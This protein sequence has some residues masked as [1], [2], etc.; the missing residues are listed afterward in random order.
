MKQE[1]IISDQV[2]SV[3]YKQHEAGKQIQVRSGAG[4]FLSDKSVKTAANNVCSV[5]VC[6]APVS[7]L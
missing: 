4:L 6:S 1:A 7:L 3:L 2:Y 5:L